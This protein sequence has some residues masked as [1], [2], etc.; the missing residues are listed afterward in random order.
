M[1]IRPTT[2][3]T[4]GG[5][6]SRHM[7][8]VRGGRG[9]RCCPSTRAGGRRRRIGSLQTPA[10]R[11][12][13]PRGHG[14]RR[15]LL[16][17]GKQAPHPCLWR[18]AGGQPTRSSSPAFTVPRALAP[19]LRPA[20]RSFGETA[21]QGC[22]ADRGFGSLRSWLVGEKLLVVAGARRADMPFGRCMTVRVALLSRHG[23][24]WKVV[25]VG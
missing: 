15:L 17:Q 21:R 24:A 13:Q 2:A 20:L 14:R 5:S 4:N 7:L 23:R 11:P 25:D 16:A 18:L 3:L 19:A 1:W 10:C 8:P 9:C 6:A 12:E 22:R